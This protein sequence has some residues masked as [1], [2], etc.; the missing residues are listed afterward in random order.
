MARDFDTVDMFPD[1]P[2]D[3]E[4]QGREANIPKAVHVI[5]TRL[6]KLAKERH[7]PVREKLLLENAASLL[8]DAHAPPEE[9]SP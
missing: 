8:V 1:M 7:R 5:V 9:V 6:R 4:P 2:R 3:P